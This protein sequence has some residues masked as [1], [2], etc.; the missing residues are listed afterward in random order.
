MITRAIAIA[1]LIA[2]SG[3]NVL[4]RQSALPKT[5]VTT[6][7]IQTWAIS[8]IYESTAADGVWLMDQAPGTSAAA[9]KAIQA[10]GPAERVALTQEVLAV[11]KAAVMSP[12]FRAEHTAKI[13]QQRNR[14]VDHGIDEQTYGTTGNLDA[15][16]I[17]TTII[18][19]IMMI[20]GFPPEA[21]RQ[22]FEEE[23]TELAE[24]IKNETGEERAKAQRHLATLNT[25][26]PLMKTNPDE[27][28]KQYTLAK[29][30]SMGGP[31]T[32]AK[33]QAASASGQDKEKIRLE[34]VHWNHYNLNA[35]LKKNLTRF[36]DAA[37][38]LDFKQ[39][40]RLEGSRL[41]WGDG[42]EMWGLTQLQYILGPAATNAAAQFARAWLTELK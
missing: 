11:I 1:G 23:R 35:I 38:K 24:T 2:I 17:T 3:V 9:L 26:A 34:Q 20:R 33:L 30:A 28:K 31:D 6:K 16:T 5:G 19:L 29:S 21:I 7:D 8:W 12:A 25:L 42:S 15:D 4:A 18:P 37:T 14:A 13:A 41:Y 27:F 32:E 40:T 39:P 22:A 10:M 36:I